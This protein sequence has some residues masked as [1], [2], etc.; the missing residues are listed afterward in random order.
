MGTPY[1]GD[2]AFLGNLL[3]VDMA[4]NLIMANGPT[5]VLLMTGDFLIGAKL[6]LKIIGTGFV[7]FHWE[8]FPTLHVLKVH[9]IWRNF[10]DR[11]IIHALIKVNMLG[12]LGT[13]S[14]RIVPDNILGHVWE[15]TNEDTLVGFS[16]KLGLA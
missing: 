6:K 14:L 12:N 2:T 16:M 7:L 1:L 13:R 8:L 5:K 10:V 3:D 9:N 15:R 11:E 4:I